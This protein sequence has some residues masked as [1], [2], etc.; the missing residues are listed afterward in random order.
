M[1]QLILTIILQDIAFLDNSNLLTFNMVIRHFNLFC[2]YVLILA[3][4]PIVC[5][6]GIS[7]RAINRLQDIFMTRYAV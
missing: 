6:L 1:Q 5:F 3:N 2:V 4:I 7:V